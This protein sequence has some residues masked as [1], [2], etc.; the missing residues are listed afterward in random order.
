M[1][2]FRDRMISRTSVKDTIQ[3]QA[4]H[5]FKPTNG[6]STLALLSTAAVALG[7]CAEFPRDVQSLLIPTFHRS[8]IIGFV[9]GVGTTFAAVPD[10]VAMVRH[11]SAAGINPRMAAIMG[12]FQIVWV[13]YGL[14]IASRPVVLWNLIAV[15]INFASVGAYGYFLRRERSRKHFLSD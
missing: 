11:R 8:E 7:G 12:T 3:T 15:L 1:R 14:L 10:L 4:S 6:A 5:R 2:G 13:Y 9:A